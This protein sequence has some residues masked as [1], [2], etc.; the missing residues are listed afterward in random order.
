MTVLYLGLG[1]CISGRS[2]CP[3]TGNFAA[4]GAVRSPEPIRAFGDYKGLPVLSHDLVRVFFRQPPQLLQQSG[5][6][7]VNLCGGLGLVV[8]DNG[9]LFIEGS[10]SIVYHLSACQ[11]PA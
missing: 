5:I 6:M 11:T 7:G 1:R 8:E 3:F 2:L 9:F 10:A 4:L